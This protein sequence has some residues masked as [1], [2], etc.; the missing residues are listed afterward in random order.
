MAESA[1]TLTLHDPSRLNI[2]E[3]PSHPVDIARAEALFVELSRQLTNSSIVVSQQSPTE[4]TGDLEKGSAD[5]DKPFDLREYL[6]SSNDANQQ[7][8]IKHKHVGVTWEDLQVDVFGGA[9]SKVRVQSS[10]SA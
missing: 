5:A 4:T 1:D 9:N 8:G 6:T 2:A 7:A 10:C 3:S